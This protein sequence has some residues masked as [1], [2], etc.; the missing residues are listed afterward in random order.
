MDKK[1]DRNKFNELR[2]TAKVSKPLWTGWR[3][4]ALIG[5]KLHKFNI[6][7]KSN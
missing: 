2:K 1:M 5:K 3:F 4:A 7:Q 6:K